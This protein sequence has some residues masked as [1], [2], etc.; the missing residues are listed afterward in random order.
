MRITIQQVKK[1]YRKFPNWKAPSPEGVQ[2]FWFKRVTSCH[3]RIARELNMLIMNNDTLPEWMTVSR[4]ILCQKDPT[5]EKEV[6]NFRPISC[7]PLMWKLMTSI[8]ANSMLVYLE[9]NSLL[10]SEQKGCR[11]KSRGTEDQLL[12]DQMVL[13]D[14][15]R[16]HTNLAMVWLDN[17]KAYDMVSHSWVLECMEMFGTADNVRKFV[18]GSMNSWKTKL[19]SS[20]EYLGTVNIR[21]GSFREIVCPLYF[22]FLLLA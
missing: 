12:I 4:T 21:R 9:E 1:G 5:K 15:K 18:A 22:L 20:R 13:R 7:L 17:R 16:R 14:C 19:I 10:P 3:E 11:R 6:S 2:G 8:L